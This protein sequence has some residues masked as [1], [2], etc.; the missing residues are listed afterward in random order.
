MLQ[1][2]IKKFMTTII[3][4]VKKIRITIVCTQDPKKK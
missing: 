4:I 2:K 3:K 1:K